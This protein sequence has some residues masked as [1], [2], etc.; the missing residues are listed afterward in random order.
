MKHDPLSSPPSPEDD[1]DNPAN[2]PR[3]TNRKM[4]EF[5]RT[6][7]ATHSVKAAA[8]A[9]GM[10][11]QSAYKLRS[12]LKGK[13]FDAAWD[14][15]FK[16]SYENLPYAALERALNGIE[17]RHYFK[18][19][20][21]GTSRRYDERLTVALLKMISN[22]NCLVLG[23]G[24]PGFEAQGRRFATLVGDIEAKGEDARDAGSAQF[25]RADSA[26]VSPIS[27]AEIM[28]ELRG[29]DPFAQGDTVS[30]LSPA[31]ACL[32]AVPKAVSPEAFRGE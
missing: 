22:Q 7:A 29:F 9:V 24:L 31:D 10:S 18:G 28:A 30:P 26:N 13:A 19:E 11:R 14:E 17:V 6:L 4:A 12:R 3:W 5:L 16:H 27:D 8:K 20:L 25:S 2:G 1:S 32:P 15:A 21:I 23:S